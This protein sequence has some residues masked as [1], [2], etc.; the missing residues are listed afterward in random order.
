MAFGLASLPADLRSAVSQE[1]QNGERV[2]YAGLPDWRGGWRD[3]VTVIVF[4]LAWSAISFTIFSFVIGLGF[5]IPPWG[6]PKN[7]PAPLWATIGMTLFLLPFVG[8]GIL[9]LT[10]PFSMISKS[11]RT[12]HVVTDAR[13]LTVVSGSGKSTESIKLDAVNFIRRKDYR[14]GAG[15]LKIAYG[16]EKDSDGDPRPLTIDWYR[17]PDARLAESIIRSNAKWAR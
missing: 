8:I 15:N 2:L 10:A 6:G 3:L 16:V 7:V 12:A 17:V 9:M 13:L 1:L 11:R 5:N 14:S 4:G